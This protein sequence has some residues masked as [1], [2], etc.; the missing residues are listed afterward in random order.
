MCRKGQGL[1]AGK[2]ATNG[3]RACQGHLSISQPSFTPGH[4]LYAPLPWLLGVNSQGV[5][6]RSENIREENPLGGSSS[7][8]GE[9]NESTTVTAPDH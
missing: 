2:P 6:G 3:S 9:G 4:S 7:R 5:G 1:E 8:S